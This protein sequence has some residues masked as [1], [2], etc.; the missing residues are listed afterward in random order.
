MKRFALAF[1][2]MALMALSLLGQPDPG[3]K[4][5]GRL[6][7]Q[8]MTTQQRLALN[9]LFEGEIV[10]D[11]TLHQSMIYHQSTG[12]LPLPGSGGGTATNAIANLNGVGT[13]TL[14]TNLNANT[15]IYTNVAVIVTNI[16][17][18]TVCVFIPLPVNP[19]FKYT[20]MP[21][22]GGYG[23]TA[24]NSGYLNFGAPTYPWFSNMM[25]AAIY[26][27]CIEVNSDGGTTSYMGGTTNFGNTDRRLAYSN[28][29]KLVLTNTS[30]AGI[31][32]QVQPG[33]YV[34]DASMGGV[35][36]SWLASTNSGFL[37]Y[38][39]RD[40]YP[41][42]NLNW[43]YYSANN[44]NFSNAINKTFTNTAAT[45]A[46]KV[47]PFDPMLEPATWWGGLNEDGSASPYDLTVNCYSNLFLWTT[48]ITPYA[49]S[50]NTFQSTGPHGDWS[51]MQT[52]EWLQN[53]IAST[54]PMKVVGSQQNTSIV[55]TGIDG[56]TSIG[57]PTDF[58][59]GAFGLHLAPNHNFVGVFSGGIDFLQDEY[60]NAQ[61]TTN[62]LDLEGLV[63]LNRG[64]S[65][66]NLTIGNGSGNEY[67]LDSVWITNQFSIGG[68]VGAFYDFER[69]GNGQYFSSYATNGNYFFGNSAYGTLYVLNSNGVFTLYPESYFASSLQINAPLVLSG[70]TNF[71]EIEDR[72]G[73]GNYT[74]LSET[75][76]VTQWVDSIYSVVLQISTNLG[77]LFP[78]G[79]TL[80]GGEFTNQV[81]AG[82]GNT[83]A[84][85][86]NVGKLIRTN[87]TGGGS[88]IATM[89]GSGTNTTL[90]N[91]NITGSFATNL[92]VA[93]ETNTGNLTVISNINAGSILVTNLT[94]LANLNANA[95]NITNLQTNGVSP[96]PGLILV[97]T[98]SGGVGTVNPQVAV[99][100]LGAQ[101]WSWGTNGPTS[102]L[103]NYNMGF[104]LSTNI[105]N[106]IPAQTN[107]AFTSESGGPGACTYIISNALA[108]G[109]G[110]TV[111]IPTNAVVST[112]AAAYLCT[113][114]GTNNTILVPV[115]YQLW[116]SAEKFTAGATW[117]DIGLSL[118]IK[119]T[120]P[121]TASGGGGG[122]SYPAFDPGT[123]STN[124]GVVIAGSLSNN[125]VL[126]IQS[127]N[128]AASNAL[129]ATFQS[130]I[131]SSNTVTSNSLLANANTF[132]G[133][134]TFSGSTNTNQV[135]VSSSGGANSLVSGAGTDP[136]NMFATT[137][138]SLQL[139]GNG[140]I[141][142]TNG[143]VSGIMNYIWAVV[144][145]G[146]NGF[147]IQ[148]QGLTPNV[149]FDDPQGDPLFNA[150]ISTFIAPNIISA[151]S[152]SPTT[153]G[154]SS[155]STIRGASNSVIG[156]TNTFG[157]NIHIK[158]QLTA[159]NSTNFDNAGNAWN[160]NVTATGF[161]DDEL[162]PNGYT[163]FSAATA[164][165]YHAQ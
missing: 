20:V 78:Q 28:A 52:N 144:G 79:I 90:T 148:T 138:G 77:I 31:S 57:I 29:C 26:T 120:A 89:G 45:Y 100:N 23:E 83:L 127:T 59:A 72:N 74:A 21:Y 115:G 165:K 70:P 27:G 123:F 140:G 151:A 1:F 48:L 46:A 104:G 13:N 66:A 11:V 155:V 111:S 110:I 37:V 61:V 76:G 136:T 116:V 94:V 135:M 19:N 73:H 47:N 64:V 121:Q 158:Y 132:K 39:L 92:T 71:L 156:F 107:V 97:T 36:S 33:I 96:P 87:A 125:L 4:Y 98:G 30:L 24:D 133:I 157:V 42:R 60:D 49:S 9:Q 63:G 18:D 75:N 56:H 82:G 44:A 154:F 163:T 2:F 53:L 147:R 17:M 122:G 131:N 8:P 95:V 146:N 112:N 65:F 117:N 150:T 137:F 12:W 103:T 109:S 68:A 14:I 149:V 114:N 81:L 160:T 7:G 62:A 34:V 113:V 101:A 88:G 141:Y 3:T 16:G 129:I 102:A 159:A 85:F 86:D 38:G 143:G 41:I 40:L 5:V 6:G 105:F 15:W 108:A 35:T 43:C 130:Q 153:G 25:K 128:T 126:Q 106:L 145:S 161:F 32:Y 10:D 118:D 93:G 162:Q 84:A 54:Q 51:N 99:T 55:S 50:I 134:N 139:N 164:V 119:S 80:T 69:S 67:F 91:A 58:G 142:T 124:N 22:V 152:D